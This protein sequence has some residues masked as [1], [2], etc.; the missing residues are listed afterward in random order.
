MLTF[1]PLKI[2]YLVILGT[3]D[4]FDIT[5]FQGFSVSWASVS[6]AMYRLV[7]MPADVLERSY[8]PR[9]IIAQRMG[10]VRPLA[11]APLTL[12]ALEGLSASQLGVF[13]VL[14]SGEKE[15]ADRVAVWMRAQEHPVMHITP[16]GVEGATHPDMFTIDMLQG[17][18]SGTLNWCPERFTDEQ[19]EAAAAALP[20][21][22]EPPVIASGLKAHGHNVTRPNHMTLKRAWRSLEAGEPFISNSE[23][24]YTEIIVE[25][26]RA[27]R[28][29]RRDTGIYGFHFLTLIRP[30]LMLVEP[31]LYRLHYK[32]VR[33][34]GP[35]EGKAVSNA[36]RLIQMQKGLSIKGSPTFF[37]QLQE[38]PAA[39]SLIGI[40]ASELDTFTLGIG[41]RAAQTVSA[42]V[43]LSPGVNSVFPLLSNYARNIRSSKM[44]ARL[45]TPRLFAAL[46]RGLRDAVGNTRLA[47]MEEHGGPVKIVCDAPIELLPIG[48]LPLGMRYDCSRLNATPGNLLMQLLV[49]FH[50]TILPPEA[51]QTMLVISTFSDDDPLKDI[52][53]GTLAA[54]F[55]SLQGK[56]NLVFK[57][58][59]STDEFVAALNDFD[60]AILIVDGH[61]ADNADEPIGRLC[62][63]KD[64]VDVWSLRG[65]LRV[66]PIVILSACDT[67]DI[68]ASSHATVGNGFLALGAQT[69]LATL[70]PVGGVASAAFV[71]RLI[72]RIAD[73]IPAA[74]KDRRRV[75]SWGEVVS[76][77]LRM[78][79]ASEVLD[80]FIGPPADIGTPRY[81]LQL[82]TNDDIN[83]N[84]DELWFDNLLRKI[85]AHRGQDLAAIEEKARSIIARAEAIRYMQ[86]GNPEAIIIDDGKTRERLSAANGR[87]P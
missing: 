64:L 16:F 32:R 4:P 15:T 8:T 63:G 70:L 45:K 44:E 61:G 65:K 36:L 42:V 10:G 68:D 66:P 76:G 38:L 33:P 73:F 55:K 24:E 20:K 43:R 87:L 67:H 79:L 51:L 27:V 13:I 26:A 6:W 77:M 2:Y 50:P 23:Q 11:W 81:N 74:I 80:V 28:K 59:R 31:A 52:L 56:A 9:H 1:D 71:S 41:L 53:T 46:Q 37:K 83:V 84:E 85:A 48:N 57:K 3:D 62:I 7:T 29:V 60:G 14:F 17:F 82:E 49:E 86:L 30:E 58:A 25:S 39:R 18:C 40:R 69:V 12:T 35:F 54:T 21:W 19:R 22:T 75:L 5:P 72:L 47:F 34:P 78:L